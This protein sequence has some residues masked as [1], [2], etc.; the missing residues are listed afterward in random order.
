MALTITAKG[1]ATN[2][3]SGSTFVMAPSATINAGTMGV[4]MVVTDNAQ[5]SGATAM[6]SDTTKTDS[7]GNVWT[8]RENTNYDPGAANAGT[9]FAIFTA[10]ITT[11]FSGLGNL[12]LNLTAATTP[13][14]GV[15]WE[16]SS[17]AGSVD[18]DT[19]GVKSAM[20]TSGQTGTAVQLT[21]GSVTNTWAVLCFVGA[22]GSSTI[23]GDSDTT[24]GSWSSQ[25]SVAAGTTTTG[26]HIGSQ[27]KVVT[28]TATQSYDVTLGT[29]EDWNAGWVVIKE[30]LSQ[31]KSVMGL[32]KA[33]VKTVDD[34]VIASVKKFDDLG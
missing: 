32:A 29:S 22:E 4:C 23:T 2:N 20:A 1:T 11:N 14:V 21:T 31:I 15:F 25:Q 16:V 19:S 26:Q 9:A 18:Y 33:S 3:S 8:R 7:V 5:G 24:N 30:I 34:L 13:K 27:G 12:T 10:P 28:A 6:W 17:S